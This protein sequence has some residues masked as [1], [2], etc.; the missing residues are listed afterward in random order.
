MRIRSTKTRLHR[1]LVTR[2]TVIWLPTSPIYLDILIVPAIPTTAPNIM[3][4]DS[5]IPTM[6]DP[7][8]VEHNLKKSVKLISSELRK[9]HCV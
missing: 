6:K 3:F 7:E 8:Y 9:L 4:Y 2:L 5:I 1:F